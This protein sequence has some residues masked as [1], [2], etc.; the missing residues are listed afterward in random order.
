D[1]QLHDLS[2]ELI[3]FFR[4]RIH[5]DTQLGCS[6]IHEVN[7]L[8]RQETVR[9]IAVRQLYS[10]DDGVVLD[11]H[12]VV[13]F[14]LF[15]NT[16]QDRNSVFNGGFVH[17]YRLE[18]A[19]Q[20]FVLFDVLLVLLERRSPDGVQFTSRQGRL[21]QVGSVHRAFSAASGTN[22]CVDLIDEENDLPIGVCHFLD[23]R[24]ETFLEFALVLRTGNQQTHIQGD[25]GLVFEVFRN[26]SVDNPLRQT[27][28]DGGLTDT[29]LTQKDR[30]VLCPAR[31]NLQNPSDFVIATNNRI[32]LSLSRQLVKVL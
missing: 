31:K 16:S 7:G 9:Y 30:V 15:L 1:L 32:D 14:V 28:Y 17:H 26:V 3:Q 18:P 24:L 13:Q 12:A 5:F 11:P 19:F 22:E 25:N 21:Q 23:D 6:L 2:V 8:I 27:F 4:Q 20:G 10:G 29:G